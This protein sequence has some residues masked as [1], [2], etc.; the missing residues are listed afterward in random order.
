MFRFTR[1]KSSLP[2]VTK[3]M[4]SVSWLC[5]SPRPVEQKTTASA[6]DDEPSPR[7]VVCHSVNRRSASGFNAWTSGETLAW[8][9]GSAGIGPTGARNA[10]GPI[11]SATSLIGTPTPGA[12]KNRGI[13]K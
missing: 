2:P 9:A 1:K 4:I 6:S 13:C 5:R 10:S 11:D 7:P 12:G 3:S 8:S